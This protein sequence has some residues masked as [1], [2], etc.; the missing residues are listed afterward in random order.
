MRTLL[1]ERFAPITSSIGFLEVPIAVAADAMERWGRNLDGDLM[2]RSLRG[3]LS[4]FLT[5]LEP[6]T[7][8]AVPRELLVGMGSWTAYF[9]CS[10]RGTDPVGP[11]GHLSRLLQCA[12]VLVD[13]VPHTVGLPGVSQG[14]MG[15]VQFTLLGPIE[16]DFLN[17]VRAVS[18]AF[19]GNKWEFNATGTV[20]AFEETDAYQAP[21]VRDRFS[22]VM[23]ERY[24]QA[25]G[26][27][28]FNP[29]EYGPEAVIFER[30]VVMPE[31][32][33]IMT[34]KETQ[35]WLEIVPGAGASLP[36]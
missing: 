31:E 36:G 7:S 28:V 34:L 26:I 5:Q 2:I 17:F 33:I 11:M 8:G 3:R 6:L 10:L 18:L 30:E 25:M 24:C 13:S 16:T 22:S 20:Q 4:E 14:R 19:D 23:L 32:P 15:S 27:D 9:D 12:A 29:D 1:D 21:R 35:C